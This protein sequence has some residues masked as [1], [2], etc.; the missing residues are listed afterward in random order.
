MKCFSLGLIVAAMFAFLPGAAGA[1]TGG[2][3]PAVKAQPAKSGAA[4]RHST[5]AAAAAPYARRLPAG[6]REEWRFLKDAAA[7]GRF[8]SDAARMAL[9]KSADP[10]VRSL[11]ATLVNHHAAKQAELQ[12]MLH[13]RNMAP[14]MLSNEQRKALNRLAKLQGARFDREWMETVGLHSQQEGVVAF[15]KASGGTHDA[16]LRTW[17]VRTL[18]AMRY[19]LASAERLTGA[20]TQFAKL[21]P[22]VPQA[23][24]KSGDLGEGNM[25]LGP[26]RPMVVKLSEPN[27]R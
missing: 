8:E 13:A 19:Q 21:A 20:A 3:P 6:Q 12:Q 23:A 18:P 2:E 22:G 24:I 27:L 9:T 10:N 26:A 1:S 7:Q 14:P 16:A 4:A 25:V 17:I 15:E 11:A 5:F